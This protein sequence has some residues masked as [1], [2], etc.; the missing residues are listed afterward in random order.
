M[1]QWQEERV[2]P[3]HIDYVW[4]LFQPDQL[5]R[6]M[7]NVVKHEL[8]EGEPGEVGAKY[9]QSYQEGKRIETYIVE[10]IKHSDQPDDKNWRIQF[11]IG[12]AFKIE[13]EYTLKKQ[14]ESETLFIYE[15]QNE[16]T[17]WFGKLMMKLM[18]RKSNDQV[19]TTF[20]E[21]VEEEAKKEAG[22][23]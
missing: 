11:S 13:T 14:S 6:I 10:T 18:S 12:K 17:N 5:Q 8:I 3:V 2:I 9:E 21:R 22:E 19:L 7:P 23:A 4:A 15:G 1:L 20:M 16:G